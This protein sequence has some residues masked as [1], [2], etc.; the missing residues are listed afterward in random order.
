MWGRSPTDGV[1]HRSRVVGHVLKFVGR[2]VGMSTHPPATR[3]TRPIQV[4]GLS[5][6]AVVEPRYLKPVADEGVT[7]VVMPIE[8]VG[9]D[10]HDQ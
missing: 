1:K 3:C 4:G 7:K 5:A 10:P 8:H 9:A 6:V 2:G